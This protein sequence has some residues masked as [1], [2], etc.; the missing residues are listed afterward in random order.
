MI[1]F[2][3]KA[4]TLDKLRNEIKKAKVLPQVRFTISEWGADPTGLL[5][6]I[7][8]ILGNA[9]LIVRSSGLA[10]DHETQSLAGH[11]SSVANVTGVEEIVSAVSEVA[12]S[13]LDQDLN[14]QVFVQPM[15][16]NVKCSGVA[17]SRDPNTGGPYI[18]VS[19]DDVTGSTDTVTS[20]T[21]NQ[22]KTA[23]IYKNYKHKISNDIVEKVVTLVTE[24]ETIFNTDSLDIEFAI[25]KDDEVYLLQVRPLIISQKPEASSEELGDALDSIANKIVE[26]NKPHPY[27]YGGRT[28]FGIMPDWNPAEIIG[29][30]PRPLA[31][32]LYKEIIT[33]NIWAYQRDNYGYKN[34]RSFPL[35][36]SLHG[37][38]YIDVRVSFNSFIPADVDENLSER[39]SN[40]YIDRLINSPSYHDKV[41]FE[42]IYSCYTLDIKERLADLRRAGFSESDIQQ[43]TISLRGLTNR[44]IHNKAGLW[45]KD[46]EKISELEQRRLKV[47]N[48]SLDEVSKIYWLLEDCKR[49]GTLPFA[50]LARAG[51]IAVQLLKSLVGVGI[52]NEL[53][54]EN[55]LGTLDTVGSALKNDLILIDREHFLKKYGHLRPGTYDILSNRYD[56]SPDDYFDWDQ[57]LDNSTKKH[58][59]FALSLEQLR[60]IENLLKEH[61]LEHD[62]LGLF[63]FIKS[64]IEGREYAKFV[65]T[66]SLSDAMKLFKKVALE[67]GFTAEEAAFADIECIK[68][69]YATSLEGKRI[70]EHSIKEGKDRYRMTK[71]LNLPPLI[72]EPED[73]WSFHSLQFEPNYITMQTVEGPV[74]SV[75]ESKNQ[76][77]EGILFIP[78]ADPGYD[79]IFSHDIKGFVTMY[80]G[81]NS[82]MAI[83]AGELGIPA[84]IGA[85]ESLFKK[86]SSAKLIQLD[87]L[88]RVVRILR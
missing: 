26:L 51:F 23:Y 41:E 80:G 17:F 3:T 75:N 58:G 79:W 16:K 10:E 22:V 20:G 62:I 83:R 9:S 60:K 72:I 27:L 5:H 38:P 4:E 45:R 65:F 64:A 67:Y 47:L 86:W 87:C 68:K 48:S 57:R 2:G 66:N 55:F 85:G 56:E 30:R 50:G 7:G 37:L 6:T 88:N 36:I 77:R 49:Y 35:L 52:L 8:E 39:L 70:I 24:L 19:Y 44:I 14:N 81:V 12:A 13:F 15:L 40:Y 21:T 69:I 32:S 11:F 59:P 74:V 73:V 42:I 33:D 71:L 76:L 46:I 84:V 61:E 53:E 29:V 63:D 78:S 25:T 34:L 43:L 54:Y 82:H 1:R 18:I 28:V 31:L